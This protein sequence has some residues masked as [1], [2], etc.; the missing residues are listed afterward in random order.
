MA[1]HTKL[2][3]RRRDAGLKLGFA[4]FFVGLT[5]FGIALFGDLDLD[6]SK[7]RL[8]VNFGTA[9]LTLA[10]VTAVGGA[11]KLSLDEYKEDLKEE[12]ALRA[13]ERDAADQQ[14]AQEKAAQD[15]DYAFYRAILDDVKSVYDAVERARLLIEAHKS[16]KTYGD[17]MRTLPDA[18]I[19][20][21]NIKRALRPSYG[22]L[23]PLVA[24]KI[25]ACTRF[26]KD[27]IFEFRD[28]YFEASQ[29]Q[30]TYEALKE[31]HLS[32]LKAGKDAGD[33]PSPNAWAHLVKLPNLEVLRADYAYQLYECRFVCHIDAISEILR[34][35]L[36]GGAQGAFD[37]ATVV[38]TLPAGDLDLDPAAKS[39][40]DRQRLWQSWTFAEKS[41]AFA[42]HYDPGEPDSAAK[43]AEIRV[44]KTLAALRPTDE[45]VGV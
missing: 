15:A 32:A 38:P 4:C 7:Q 26:L 37:L 18:V 23:E 8:L 5:M 11:F 27:L 45:K 16:A 29:R 28:E 34:S 33:F 17:Q 2:S 42:H 31:A 25:N 43:L 30:S 9:G 41:A 24:P 6:A 13:K 3:V 10:F 22:E 12:R 40:M 44:G 19:T 21:H 35:K 1:S 36:P 20:L 14:R 39:D